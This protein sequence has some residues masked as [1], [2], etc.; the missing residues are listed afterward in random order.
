MKR[1]TALFLSLMLMLA[2][3][4]PF[5]ASAAT[6]VVDSASYTCGILRAKPEFDAKVVDYI[7]NGTSVTLEKTA[8]AD[9]F[10]VTTEDGL[11]GYMHKSV[12]SKAD[13]A[14]QDDVYTINK[15]ANLRAEASSESEYLRGFDKGES[16]LLI[17]RG[18]EWSR[19]IMR[20]KTGY[21]HNSVYDFG[22]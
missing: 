18:T 20:G 5:A 2:L 22:A 7:R 1:K 12:L 3:T 11:V 17:E 16:F 14:N 4:V 9:W 19:V 13:Y 8:D 21:I 15:A 10:K 6:V